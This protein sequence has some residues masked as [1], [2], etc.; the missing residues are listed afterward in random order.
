MLHNFCQGYTII[1]RLGDATY[2][3]PPPHPTTT[4]LAT[5]LGR[6]NFLKI[7]FLDYKCLISW[8]KQIWSCKSCD[9][10]LPERDALKMAQKF[11]PALT[12]EQAKIYVTVSAWIITPCKRACVYMHV[13]ACGYSQ[14]PNSLLFSVVLYSYPHHHILL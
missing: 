2:T 13:H 8:L 7:K 9:R 3:P 4:T 11:N 12:S 1:H 5:P 10:E 14:S 6:R